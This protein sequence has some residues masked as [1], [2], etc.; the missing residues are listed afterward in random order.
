[1]GSHSAEI[2]LDRL[3]VVENDS[4]PNISPTPKEVRH[5]R[6]GITIDRLGV[7]ENN[8]IPI[9]SATAKDAGHEVILV[10][11]DADPQ[12]AISRMKDFKPDVWRIL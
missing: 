6:V 2:T 10:E 5:L 12:K 8:S 9:I 7:V 3:E 11:F 4:L 1:M